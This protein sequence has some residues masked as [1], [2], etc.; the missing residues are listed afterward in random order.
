MTA[1]LG[2]VAHAYSPGALRANARGTQIQ[3]LPELQR[4][5]KARQRN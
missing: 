4:E 2:L 3:G 5:F 1:L